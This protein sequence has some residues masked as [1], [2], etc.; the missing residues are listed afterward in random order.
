MIAN[1][2]WNWLDYEISKKEGLRLKKDETEVIDEKTTA[3]PW[4]TVDA[5]DIELR[6]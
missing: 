4:I 1:A 2:F 6:D 5:V 3:M